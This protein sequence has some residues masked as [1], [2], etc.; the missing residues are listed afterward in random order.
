MITGCA[1]AQP[2]HQGTL[3]ARRLV[4]GMLRSHISRQLLWVTSQ[5]RLRMW[6]RLARD[7]SSASTGRAPGSDGSRDGALTVGGISMAGD[8][9]TVSI[10]GKL[11]LTKPASGSDGPSTTCVH[12]SEPTS[13][14]PVFLVHLRWKRT[15][16]GRWCSGHPPL[17]SLRANQPTHLGKGLRPPAREAPE[18]RAALRSAS[19]V[20]PTAQVKGVTADVCRIAVT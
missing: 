5:P 15:G 12:N 20:A 14:A 1:A 11:C 16:S 4:R 2:G 13:S 8:S 10:I 9:A 6:T 18:D 3:P 19:W 7:L 17:A